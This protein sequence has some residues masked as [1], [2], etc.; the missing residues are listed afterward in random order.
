MERFADLPISAFE[1]QGYL[2][3]RRVVSVGWQY[4]FNN[5]ELRRAA[6][7]PPFLLSFRES[8][9]AFAGLAP[10]TCSAFFTEHG[11]SAAISW[12]KGKEAF[13]EVVSI[14]LVSSC[15]A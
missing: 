12:H 11:V 7:I 9:A 14:S 8:A 10:L 2:S 6:Q 5:Q 13:G 15:F 3:R 4:D 1:F